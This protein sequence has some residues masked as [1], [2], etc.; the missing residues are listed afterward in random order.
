VSYALFLSLNIIRNHWFFSSCFCINFLILETNFLKN[1]NYSSNQYPISVPDNI[2]ILRYISIFNY[3]SP[4]FYHIKPLKKVD[5]SFEPELPSKFLLLIYL[6]CTFSLLAHFF[7]S[8]CPLYPR[9][10]FCISS[11][12]ATCVFDNICY[13]SQ[14]LLFRQ[15]LRFSSIIKE[16]S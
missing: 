2:L 13:F 9:I 5:T 15:V 1:N 8:H 10:I 14:N 3:K 7:S 4:F 16:A 11:G 6:L 12:W